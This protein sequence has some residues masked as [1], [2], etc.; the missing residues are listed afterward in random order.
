MKINIDQPIPESMNDERC[1]FKCDEPKGSILAG[2]I[3]MLLGII[4]TPIIIQL[5]EGT[6][7]LTLDGFLM[8]LYTEF[9]RV[10]YYGVSPTTNEL[11]L[12]ALFSLVAG[13]V[14]IKAW[15]GGIVTVA[16][17]GIALIGFFFLALFYFGIVIDYDLFFGNFLTVLLTI[18]L[19]ILFP[20]LFGVFM[21]Y[22]IMKR[23]NCFVMGKGTT[24]KQ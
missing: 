17:M 14:T 22:I 16:F 15:K 9:A 2:L 23:K 7:P 20:C 13:I 11:M 5:L 3:V 8:S 6:L 1:F 12:Y 18:G 10:F 21:S 24:L 19:S 4:F